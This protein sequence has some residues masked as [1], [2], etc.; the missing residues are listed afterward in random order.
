MIIDTNCH[1]GEWPFRK[2]QHNDASG[3]LRLM[4]E[5]GIAQ[6]WAGAFE[7]IFYRDCGQANRDLLER[8][9]DHRDRLL[10]WAAINPAFPGW[11]DDLAEALEA[12]M[13][14]VRLYPNYHAYELTDPC[15]AE[16][17]G[18]LSGIQAA[19]AAP[20][21]AGPTAG[22][23]S[24]RAQR[25]T[26]RLGMPV[27]IYHKVVDE[28]LHHWRC[29]VPATDMR[30]EPLVRDFPDQPLLLCGCGTIHAQELSDAIRRG[31]VYMEI[32]R[33]EGIEGVRWLADMIG[34]DRVVFGSHAPYFYMQAAQLKLVEA[35]L[36]DDEREAML[37]GNATR[38]M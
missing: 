36:S 20:C 5:H 11:E 18:R 2:L 33:L 8:I 7:G 35:G 22:G 4:D 25:D 23:G 28:R 38:L 21:A 31:Q 19:G 24:R 3:L 27:A 37:H 16:L 12:G 6:A 1:L 9:G 34:I 29:M 26:R 13:V 10:P 14:G 15:V 17:L 32:S 30:I